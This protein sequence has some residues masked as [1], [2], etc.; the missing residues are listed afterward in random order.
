MGVEFGIDSSL[1]VDSFKLACAVDGWVALSISYSS[2]RFAR[3]D[4]HE[5]QFSDRPKNRNLCFLLTVAEEIYSYTASSA[6]HVAAF[7]ADSSIGDQD[8]IN[9]G[10]YRYRKDY[11]VVHRVLHDH[12]LNTFKDSSHIWGGFYH[13]NF[14]E[15]SLSKCTQLTAF[16]RLA[17]PTAF[18]HSEA[19]RANS[20]SSALGRFLALYH[21]LELS[22]DYDLVQEIKSL[23]D[24]L[25]R[26]GKILASFDH[27][28][29]PRLQ[30]LV[31]K[32]WKD[33]KTLS[34]ALGRAFAN[35][36]HSTRLRE[37]LFEYEKDG[38]PWRFKDDQS[39]FQ[40]FLT[41]AETSFT[42][43]HFSTFKLGWTLEFLQKSLAFTIYRF[44]C[45]IAHA[46]IGECVLSAS[47]DLF[48]YEV[49]EPLLMDLLSNVFKPL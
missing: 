21:L 9:A 12:Y 10:T 14:P 18:H 15:H 41:A 19:F 44:R 32:Y 3:N 8:E 27:G 30:R 38:F 42:Q 36:S 23:P 7:L 4:I 11:I 33:E 37:L 20:D 40:I 28:E 35:R 16:P 48:V 22:F 39:K 49:G 25:K 34:K 1:S 43:S 17:L 24:D 6:M 31:S 13:D 47:D 29:L 26:V 5:I 2:P 45:A 46:S